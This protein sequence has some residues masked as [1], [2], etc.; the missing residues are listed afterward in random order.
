M[1]KWIM[2]SVL[3]ICFAAVAHAE[4]KGW[5]KEKYVKQTKKWAEHPTKGF[6]FNKAKA[7]AKFDEL[8]ADGDGLLTAEEREAGGKNAKKAKKAKEAKKADKGDGMTKN[9]WVKKR[10][11]WARKDPKWNPSKEKIEAKFDKLDKNGDGK[12]TDDE[13]E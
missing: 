1:K 6:K 13:R 9:E 3:I 8:D 10:M 5:T 7:E 12:L 11:E 2:A 4:E